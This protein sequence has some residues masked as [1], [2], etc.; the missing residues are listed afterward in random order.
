MVNG[1][2]QGMERVLCWALI[3]GFVAVQLFCSVWLVADFNWITLIDFDDMYAVEL[4][5]GNMG[6]DVEGLWHWDVAY[7][8][9]LF[10]LIPVYRVIE[11][12]LGSSDPLLAYRYLM[13]VHVLGVG[14]SLV[15]LEAIL[16]RSGVPVLVPSAVILLLVTSPLFFSPAHSLKG[17]ANIVLAFL[18]L[19]FWALMRFQN[20]GREAWLITSIALAALA[21][22]LKWWGLFL[23]AP[24]VYVMLTRDDFGEVFRPVIRWRTVLLANAVSSVLLVAIIIVQGTALLQN[25]PQRL[26]AVVALASTSLLLLG[27]VTNVSVGAWGLARYLATRDAAES[28]GARLARV[29]YHAVGSVCV[30]VTGYLV[31][32]APFL[33]SDQLRPSI[34]VRA[35]S[36]VIGPYA[37]ERFQV[38]P[39]VD[40]LGT[41]IAEWLTTMVSVGTLPLFLIPALLASLLLL[42]R[43]GEWERRRLTALLLFPASLVVFWFLLIIRKTESMQAMILPF[44]VTASLA[45]V[46]LWAL[47]LARDRRNIVLTALGLLVVGQVAIQVAPTVDVI[48]SYGKTIDAISTANEALNTSL[49]E[50]SGGTQDLTLFM[51]GREFPIRT[52]ARRTRYLSEVQY[53]G[54]LER[55]ERSCRQADSGRPDADAG[56]GG[57]LSF[58]VVETDPGSAFAA[59]QGT[60]HE[61]ERSGCL[62]RVSE[63]AGDSYR[64]GVRWQFSF[65]LYRLPTL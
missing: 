12:V 9:K 53:T 30:F 52:G 51:P 46:A 55:V 18:L 47:G 22:A 64:R 24:Q 41:N 34:G 37:Q 6:R 27:V 57:A 38:L 25:P 44:V 58:M 39:L 2:L 56:G 31:F 49:E 45:P 7:G 35:Q 61:L 60:V 54:L 65:T 23:L 4:F 13:V 5:L 20:S 48:S 36:V 33:L 11:V 28:S 16:R 15:M 19:S 50:A 42:R 62:D 8:S 63:I 29:T 26:L 32:A 40:R 59:H 1:R 21:A 43:L 14:V 3:L 17:D 10:L